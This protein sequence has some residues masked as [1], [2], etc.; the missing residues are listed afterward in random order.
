MDPIQTN[1]KS[2]MGTTL[3]TILCAIAFFFIV[4]FLFG[5]L[6]QLIA[7]AIDKWIWV[8]GFIIVIIGL[9]IKFSGRNKNQY[10]VR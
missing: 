6:K 3:L 10:P 9:K 1:N 2:Q 4:A 8:V 7:L 5:L